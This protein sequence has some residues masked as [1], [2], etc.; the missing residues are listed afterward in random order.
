[1]RILAI[2]N[3]HN[4]TAGVFEDGK[5]SCIYHEEKFTNK[6]NQSGIPHNTLK[7][8][9]QKYKMR[10]IDICVFASIDQIMV[11]EGSVGLVEKVGASFIRKYYNWF[12]YRVRANKLTEIIRRLL[13]RGHITPKAQKII[14]N[15]M[16]DKYGF[17]SE[18]IIFSDHHTNHCLSTIF[19][20]GL[21]R[22]K[23]NTLLVS[24][25]GA[26]DSLC[27]R[28]IKY[29]Y[30]NNR[31]TQ[32]C[33]TEHVASPALMYRE[34]TTFLGMKALEHEHKVMG[35]AAYVADEKYYK[36]IY[37]ELRKAVW[38]DKESLTFKSTF[39]I[40]YGRWLMRDKFVGKRFDNL[41]AAV[42]KFAEDLVLEWVQALVKNTKVST[43]AFSGGIFNGRNK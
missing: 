2:N 32:I 35:L 24:L 4:A 39:N 7:Y 15:I 27:S 9:N 26:G 40:A 5:C 43:L 19:F 18:K 34:M 8:I 30:K 42:Q 36:D 28:V 1:M 38:V 22:L 29:N 14:T 10:S 12:E 6:K 3:G 23:E 11:T 31:L 21:D 17:K 20:F 13:V 16:V 37:D 25:D 33:Q 41:G